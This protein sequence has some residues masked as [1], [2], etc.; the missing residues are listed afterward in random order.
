MIAKVVSRTK[1]SDVSNTSTWKHVLAA[2]ARQDDEQY[3]QM[4][5]LLLLFS[6]DSADGDD[7][8]ERAKEIQPAVVTRN[9]ASKATGNVVFFRNTTV[10]TRPIASG[11]TIKTADGKV[12]TTTAAGSIG[13]GS[14][15]SGSIPIVAEVA[16]TAG[17]VEAGTI[18]KFGSK[19]PGIDGVSNPSA[20][21]FGTDKE[22][23]DS[24]R[25][26]IR[27]YISTLARSTIEA[28]EFAVLGAVDPDTGAVVMFAKAIEDPVNRGYVTLYIDDGTGS[29]S[30]I[31]AVSGEIV[32]EGL[33]GPPAGS[34]VG[35]EVRLFLN[36]IAID[37]ETLTLSSSESGPLTRNVH[38]YINPA[39]GQINFVTALVAGEVITASY[40]RYTGLIRLCQKIID[41]DSADRVNYPGYRAGGVLVVAS[42]PQV[43]IQTVSLSLIR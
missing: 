8:D 1:L 11:T 20:T 29:A 22:S 10:G 21:A 38:Y 30:S 32:T 16:G 14:Q 2:A 31:E 5:L 17:N 9:L 34:A 39:S 37:A 3:Y 6:I 18:V 23:D 4:S 35:G 36:N 15:Y 7:L 43:L 19:P 24:F 42:T 27:Q 40:N 28:L 26:R 33:A 41:G 13:P 12:F 25:S